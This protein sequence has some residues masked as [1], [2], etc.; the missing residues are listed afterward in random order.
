MTK[1]EPVSASR[2]KRSTGVEGSTSVPGAGVCIT[3]APSG[4]FGEK[5]LNERPSTSPAALRRTSTVCN[6]W[7]ARSGTSIISRPRDRPTSTELRRLAGVP[8]LG[9]CSTTLPA[10]TSESKRS[11]SLR[12]LTVTPAV[13]I[14]TCAS[15]SERPTTSGKTTSP[16]RTKLLNAR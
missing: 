9:T 4:P 13:A 12:Q 3:T 10:A 14:R 7:S 8:P 5:T 6:V 2:T 11:R 1:L 15:S 16:R